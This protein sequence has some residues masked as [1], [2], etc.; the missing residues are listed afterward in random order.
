MET[1]VEIVKL[2]GRRFLSKLRA[3]SLCQEKSESSERQQ[4]KIGC[5]K[6]PKFQDFSVHK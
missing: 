5:V 3:E 4:K 1:Y 6:L 2:Q